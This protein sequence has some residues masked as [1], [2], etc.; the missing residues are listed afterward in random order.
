MTDLPA[1]APAIRERREQAIETISR[2]YTSGQIDLDD[3]ETRLDRLYLARSV[4]E[5]LEVQADLPS[6]PAPVIPPES[7]NAG[8]TRDRQLLIAVLGGTERKGAW[9]PARRIN[10]FAMMGGLRLDFR[11]ALFAPG[12]TELTVIAMMGGVEILVP[13]GLRVECEGFG[14]MGGF[15]GRSQS[16]DAEHPGD[17]TLRIRGVAIMGGVEVTERRSGETATERKR[18]IKDGKSGTSSGG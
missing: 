11:Q 16:G 15:E 17:P 5:I 2:H 6:L 14:I 18:R 9:T 7:I 4:A 1:R 3:F 13:P 10:A 12:L 8:A